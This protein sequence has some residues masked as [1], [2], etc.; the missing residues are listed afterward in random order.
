MNRSLTNYLLFEDLLD[1]LGTS[2]QTL[3]SLASQMF[4]PSVKIVQENCN[5]KLGKRL[6]VSPSINGEV[7]V[8]FNGTLNPDR[9]IPETD[10]ISKEDIGDWL[11]SSIYT[12]YVRDLHYCTS[13]GGVCACCYAAT[14]NVAAPEVG[15]FQQIQ[16]RYVLH[17][18]HHLASSI[19]NSYSVSSDPATYD[20]KVIYINNHVVEASE[21]VDGGSF[22]TFNNTLTD[23]DYIRIDSVILSN[24][25]FL[26]YLANTFSGD[27]LGIQD[28]PNQHITLPL[29]FID[30]NISEG[31]LDQ[32]FRQLEDLKTVD[33]V[34]L[35]YIHGLADRVEKALL[36]ITLF[37]I[38]NDIQT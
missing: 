37:S 24:K 26:S 13:V 8:T 11:A 3:T 7:K 19:I 10:R 22:I 15:T 17:S 27:L 4:S 29:G 30:R 33:Q 34:Y 14:F 36:L 28:V 23:G 18:D 32:L 16:N 5:T 25:P 20:L 38:H 6:S 31:Q 9:T 2:N 12:T 1:N 21:Y 35:D